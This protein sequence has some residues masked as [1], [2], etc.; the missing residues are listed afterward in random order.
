MEYLLIDKIL[1]SAL[2]EDIGHGDITT[3]A[4]TPP[5]HKSKAVIIAKEDLM[6]A[7]IRFIERVFILTD[8]TINFRAH[9]KDG[10]IVKEGAAIAAISGST[11]SLLTAERV[12]LNLLQRLSGIA[13]LTNKFVKE[14]K[15]LHVKIVD[16]RKTTP[17]LRIFE[18][19]AVK[20]G[21]GHNHRFGL[22]DGVLIKDNHI[23]AVGGIKK[24]VA[25]AK[26]NAHHMLKIEVEVK[27]LKEA[28]EALSAGADII[29][30]DNMTLGEMRKAVTITR[31]L[32]ASTIIEASGN[33]S[34]ENAGD[35]AKTGVDMIS[36]GALTHSA[37]AVD[38]SM[39]LTI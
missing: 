8:P 19:Y 14:V 32:N 3:S 39:K 33:V 23:V 7:G 31:K 34:L 26:S 38:I 9:K 29:M 13:T 25:L 1:R 27:N 21:G 5:N 20:A 15:G 17:G 37:R 24:A 11:R 2:K 22:F 30:F 4:V 6:L 12:A 16:T 36:I 28:K 35:I 18:K 10:D